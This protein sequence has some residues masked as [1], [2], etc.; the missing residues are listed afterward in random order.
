MKYLDRIKDL[1]YGYPC[2]SFKN[3]NK[4]LSIGLIGAFC[5][6]QSVCKYGEF[7]TIHYNG[8]KILFGDKFSLIENKFFVLCDKVK[9]IIKSYPN[10]ILMCNI[11]EDNVVIFEG[12][13]IY[14][15]EFVIVDTPIT[16]KILYR[17]IYTESVL[18]DNTIIRFPSLNLPKYKY[19][20]D[21]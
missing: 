21:I 4:K 14:D 9:K 8:K 18:Q 6:I 5:T 1:T 12:Y 20:V 19:N 10:L 2:Y 15:R 17:G 11:Y 16:E 3:F 13:D 7:S